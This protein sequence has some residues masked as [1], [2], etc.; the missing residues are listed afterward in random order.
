VRI[1]TKRKILDFIQKHSDSES[2]LL[3]WFDIVERATW[4][5]F[6]DLRATF[7]SVDTV[8]RCTV[9]NIA[10]NRYRLIARVNYHSKL[11]FVLFVLTHKEYD[12]KG[13]V[14]KCQQKR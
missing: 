9:F 3:A 13:W 11:V 5:S 10:Q 1:I 8:S 2:S 4:S 12:A 6:A 7:N 14:E